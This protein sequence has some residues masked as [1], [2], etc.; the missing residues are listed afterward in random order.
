VE[1]HLHTEDIEIFRI[2]KMA[3]AS[4]LDFLNRETLLVI[5]VQRIETHLRDKFCQNRSIGCEYIKIFR[6][7]KMAAAAILDF[8]ICEIL[9]TDGVWR[10]E[11][12]NCAK[13]CHNRSFH[14][15]DVAI[16]R[17]FKMAAV[18]HIGFVWGTIG[19]PTVSTCVSL[20][21]CKIGYDRCSSYYNV[22]ISIFDAFGV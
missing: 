18:R 20:S 21:L 1:T 2:F 9:L 12:H 13:F 5:R 10:A 7:F 3:A 8:Q 4:I 22:N 19:P 11:A 15:R 16:F 17:I 14:C 6:F